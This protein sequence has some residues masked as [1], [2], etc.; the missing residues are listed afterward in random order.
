MLS[1][2]TQRDADGVVAEIYHDIRAVFGVPVVVLV[3]RALATDE[4][5]LQAAWE[6]VRPNLLSDE[7]H[8]FARE[9]GSEPGTRVAPVANPVLTESDL[10]RGVLA[11]TI[12]AFHRVNTRNAIALT[13]LRDGHV[14]VAPQC[15]SPAP[16]W[17]P[18]P[19]LPV[20]DLSTLPPDIDTVLR[21]F[22]A[23][24]TGGRDPLVI[25]SLLRCLAPDGR[26]LRAVWESL[27]PV[28]GTDS[29]D[30]QV[31]ATQDRITSLS[32]KLPYTITRCI[33]ERTRAI[34]SDFLRTIPA[35][36]ITAPLIAAALQLDIPSEADARRSDRTSRD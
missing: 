9:L 23:P 7:M 27:R 32:Q 33:D 4:G 10:D 2:V 28:L 34:I 31:I 11:K 13:A 6:A 14:G 15:R 12:A 26:L 20:A 30:A 17:S 19:I 25:P 1:E 29:F 35:M 3:Y 18:S 16:T 36:V 5:R 8:C 22:S 21:E 24:I